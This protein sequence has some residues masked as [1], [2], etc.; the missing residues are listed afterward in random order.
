MQHLSSLAQEHTYMYTY[1][2][3]KPINLNVRSSCIVYH[4]ILKNYI[5]SNYIVLLHSGI[6]HIIMYRWSYKIQKCFTLLNVSYATCQNKMSPIPCT[7]LN[8]PLPSP[9]PPLP[10]QK[11][12][13]HELNIIQIMTELHIY[14]WSLSLTLAML[15]AWPGDLKQTLL[16]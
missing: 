7:T 4:E 2:Q 9:S 10:S 8:Y 5:N 15:S 11:E 14:P 6:H 12:Q 1:L 3:I 16:C 13:K